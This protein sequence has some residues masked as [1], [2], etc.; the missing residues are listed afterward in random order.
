MNTPT[1]SHVTLQSLENYRTAASQAVVA[2]RVG[3]HR[4]VNAVNGA[5][6]NSVYPRTAKLAPR[7]TDRMDEVR[8]NVTQIVVKGID[9]VADQAEKAIEI[10]STAAATQ[11]TKAADFAAGI[12]N[13]MVANGLQVAARVSL[14]GAKL[15]LVMSS[16][17]ADGAQ[18]LAGAAGGRS[19][20]DSVHAMKKAMKK[21]V[22]KAGQ[23]TARQ[24]AVTPVT[25]AT[26][27]KRTSAAVA[28]V[29]PAVRRAKA[30]IEATIKSAAKAANKRVSKVAKAVDAPVAKAQGVVRRAKKAAADVM[31]A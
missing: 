19:V 16:R 12:D 3:S 1:F 25:R 30:Q 28:P 2:Y 11:F 26:R 17:V 10:S 15:A 23:K 8:G 27:A 24:V 14:P 18:A 6:K 21:A 29:T 5:L 7:A 13:P 4:L 22:K 9:Q 20:Q 31:A